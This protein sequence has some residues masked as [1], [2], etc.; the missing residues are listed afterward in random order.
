MKTLWKRIPVIA[1]LVIALLVG[2]SGCINIE[3]NQ[4]INSDGSSEIELIYDFSVLES[5]TDEFGGTTDEQQNEDMIQTCEDFA[6]NTTWKNA[7]CI[8]EDGKITLR[9]EVMLNS[10][11]FEVEKS[12]PCITYRYD[13]TDINNIIEDASIGGEQGQN[14]ADDSI[15]DMKSMAEMFG[16]K[17]TYTLEMPGE[18]VNADIGDIK[19][20][21]VTIN[22]FDLPDDEPVYIESRE[23]NTYGILVVTCILGVML[24]VCLYVVMRKKKNN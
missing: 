18:I 10:S 24:L 13:A 1:T 8:S 21:K 15:G 3:A 23:L 5:S 6:E 4:K 14:L 19:D 20:N 12:I 11:Y 2:M 7:E 16:I 9:G 17:M 22:M